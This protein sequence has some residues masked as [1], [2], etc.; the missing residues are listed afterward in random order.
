MTTFPI[1]DAVSS[2]HQFVRPPICCVMRNGRRSCRVRRRRGLS[3]LELILVCAVLIAVAALALPALYGPME[4]QRLKKT[5]DL[6]RAEWSKARATAM[7][8]GRMHVFQY[9]LGSDT[10]SLTPLY[11]ETEATEISGGSA[12]AAPGPRVLTPRDMLSP[13]GV[14]GAKLPEGIRFHSGQTVVDQRMQQTEAAGT[15]GA[16]GGLGLSQ[17][18]VF[19][20]DGS[21]SDARVVLTN[22]RF[23]VEVRLRGL[24]GISKASDLLAAEELTP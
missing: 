14:S 12:A 1:F 5:A 11:D 21:A 16:G 17:P 3:L 6:L 22:D 20:P 23:F 24:T 15:A 4:D 18:I 8:T 13:I 9:E 7:K 2:D 19:Y 10:Y